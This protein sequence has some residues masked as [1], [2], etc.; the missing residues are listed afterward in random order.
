MTRRAVKAWRVR[1]GLIIFHPYHIEFAPN[2][3]ASLDKI[4]INTREQSGVRAF[5]WDILRIN[6]NVWRFGQGAQGVPLMVSGQYSQ[7][8][9]RPTPAKAVLLRALRLAF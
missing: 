4:C 3:C 1:G 9:P 5:F 2:S 8:N 7:H 6:L